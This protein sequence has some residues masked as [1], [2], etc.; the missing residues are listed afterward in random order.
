[1]QIING[2]SSSS[3]TLSYILMPNTT[4]AFTIG[5]AS[6][7]YEDKTFTTN[8][9][10]VTIVKGSQNLKLKPTVKYQTKR[11]QKIYLFVQQ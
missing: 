3:L 6:I 9:I 8:P 10:K 1:M 11:L 7:Q 4:G 2:V 5:S